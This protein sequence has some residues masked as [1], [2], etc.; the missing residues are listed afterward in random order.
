MEGLIIN[1]NCCGKVLTIS[2]GL[3][4]SPPEQITGVVKKIHLCVDCYNLTFEYLKK[5]NKKI[6][7]EKE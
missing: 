7:N 2:G 1:C 3:L 6:K 4:F 5:L